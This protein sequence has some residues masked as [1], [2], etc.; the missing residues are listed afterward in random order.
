ML[1]CPPWH[2]CVPAPLAERVRVDS[3]W[4]LVQMLTEENSLPTC[5]L[6]KVAQA[7]CSSCQTYL[8]SQLPPPLLAGIISALQ[9]ALML[10]LQGLHSHLQAQLGILCGCQLILQFRHL[11]P[12]VTGRLFSHLAGSLQLVHLVGK[13]SELEASARIE[14]VF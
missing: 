12:Q 4:T 11:C 1:I 13:G 14:M 5:T 6:A 7:R 2:G 8:L 10:S 9:V 3:K